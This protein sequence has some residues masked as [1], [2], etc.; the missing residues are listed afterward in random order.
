MLSDVEK[1]FVLA[2]INVDVLTVVCDVEDDDVVV[3]LIV[4]FK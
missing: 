3:V 2:V 1:I 4:L